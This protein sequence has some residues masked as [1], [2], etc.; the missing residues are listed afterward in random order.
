MEGSLLKRHRAKLQL[1][2]V[3]LLAAV[4]LGALHRLLHGIRFQDLRRA[5]AAVEGWRI[6][7]ALALTSLSYLALTIYDVVALRVVT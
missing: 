6:A 2:L 3:A 7:A 4:A 1:V 5:A